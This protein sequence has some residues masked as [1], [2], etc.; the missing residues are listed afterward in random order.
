MLWLHVI[1]RLSLLDNDVNWIVTILYGFIWFSQDLICDWCHPSYRSPCERDRILDISNSL[2]A[3]SLLL[4]F[5]WWYSPDYILLIF[6]LNTPDI[7]MIFCWYSHDIPLIVFNQMAPP[8]I[9]CT[10]NVQCYTHLWY[11]VHP[12]SLHPMYSVIHTCNV[13]ATLLCKLTMLWQH[14]RCYGR[15]FS[16]AFS[17]LCNSPRSQSCIRVQFSTFC[18]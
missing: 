10:Y 9:V 18:K 7:L 6:S 2:P 16:F 8:T 13:M 3:L 11:Y 4:I 17:P 12:M 5:S 1:L 15:E 14:L